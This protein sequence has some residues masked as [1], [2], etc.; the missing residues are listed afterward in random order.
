MHKGV[1]V[2]E[3][4]LEN[5]KQGSALWGTL[6]GSCQSHRPQNPQPPGQIARGACSGG[7]CTEQELRVPLFLSLSLPS[8][9]G[10]DSDCCSSPAEL[11]HP[12][13][14]QNQPSPCTGSQE[15][16]KSPS[17]RETQGEAEED[18]TMFLGSHPILLGHPPQL[19]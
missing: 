14:G 17:D 15:M 10:N 2:K 5:A 1:A 6:K 8:S 12:L 16:E 3:K 18:Q 19:P 4:L 9:F 7:I 11:K 13:R